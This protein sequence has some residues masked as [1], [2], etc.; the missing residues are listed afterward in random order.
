[1][2]AA[3]TVEGEVAILEF[4]LTMIPVLKPLHSVSTLLSVAE[5]LL[6]SF[7]LAFLKFLIRSQAVSLEFSTTQLPSLFALPSH[8]PK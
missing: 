3:A 6:H 8:F 4:H 7:L 1:M 5:A 2:E